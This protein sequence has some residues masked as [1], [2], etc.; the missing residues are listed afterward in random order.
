[1]IELMFVEQRPISGRTLPIDNGVT[2][3]RDGCDL[4]L[5]DPEVSRRHAVVRQLVAG[6][7]IEDLGSRNGT[8]VNDE[9][10]DGVRELHDGDEVRLGQTVWL[11]SAPG[12]APRSQEQPSDTP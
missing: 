8:F 4:V 7:A 1:M 11:V 3:G 5:P 6:P 12:S 9:R 10:I 2:I